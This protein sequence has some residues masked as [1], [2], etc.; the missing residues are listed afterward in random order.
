MH[1]RYPEPFQLLEQRFGGNVD[2]R[3]GRT[4][5]VAIVASAMLLGSLGAGSVVG[6]AVQPSPKA[7][8]A[9]SPRPTIPPEPAPTL[10]PSPTNPVLKP[11]APPAQ[12]GA[13]PSP[14]SSVGP[15]PGPHASQSADPHPKTPALN[16]GAAP[17]APGLAVKVAPSADIAGLA[18]RYQLQVDHAILASRGIYLLTPR[19]PATSAILH[20]LA[21]K[22]GKDRAVIYAEAELPGDFQDDSNFHAW[23]DGS[24]TDVGTDEQTYLTQASLAYLDLQS[25]HRVANGGGVR[26]ALLD[27]GVD[28]SQPVLAG[29]LSP[30]GYDYVADDPVP[31]D[32]RQGRDGNH[33]GVTDEAYGHG[34]HTAGLIAL[35]APEAEIVPYRVLDSDG[36]GDF[37]LVAE[38][39][40]DAVAAKVDVINMS[41]GTPGHLASKVLRDALTNAIKHDVVVVAAGGNDAS[42]TDYSPASLPDIVGVGATAAGNES[43]ASFSNFG[44]GAFL[45]APGQDIVSTVPGRR[46]GRWSGT[47]MAAAI[48]SG[49]V[50]VLRSYNPALNRK[51]V[52]DRMG[53]ATRKLSGPAKPEHG[54]IDILGALNSR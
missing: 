39:I 1:K 41:F 48:A 24:W 33:N 11:Q 34:T 16:G 25:V 30:S 36:Q 52:T 43:L 2:G 7:T 13:L 5:F 15:V 14:T 28:F 12:P 8:F 50:A 32:E 54:L 40:N 27:S 19:G 44:K 18:M 31:A 42:K 49:E 37:H 45:A 10:P 6:A 9:A 51:Q 53:R 4:R 20:S 23:T 3:F 46:F 35:V 21:D 22:L 47:S 29:H 17:A 38:A 26:V